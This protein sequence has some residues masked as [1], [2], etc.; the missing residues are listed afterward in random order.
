MRR[1]I[2]RIGFCMFLTVVMLFCYSRYQTLHKPVF[3]LGQ[4]NKSIYLTFDDGPS[5]STT[6]LV[7]DILKEEDVRATFFIIG[8]Q[9][10]LRPAIVERIFQNG[11]ALGIHSYSHEYASI[12]SSPDALLRDI[13]KCSAVLESILGLETDLY[14]FPGGSF[15]LREELVDCVKKAGYRYV[16]W[17][18]SCRDA[19][20]VGATA[21]ELFRAAIDTP[22]DKN[23]T[24]MLLHDSAHHANTAE[25][26]RKIIAYYKGK[27]YAFRTL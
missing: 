21:D 26:L 7:L 12:Y 10:E 6:P 15:S 3:A 2:L 9:A 8:R 1:K 19:E 27:G 24:V 14:R 23:H 16:D 17:N 13:K 20:L 18:A 11:H 4:E 5:D 22:A 25:A